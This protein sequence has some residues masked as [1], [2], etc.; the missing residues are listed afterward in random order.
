VGMCRAP[1]D[2]MLPGVAT[3]WD[4]RVCSIALCAGGGEDEKCS[5]GWRVHGGAMRGAVY[6]VGVRL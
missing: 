3:A 1:R 4:A 5:T 6:M 2:D